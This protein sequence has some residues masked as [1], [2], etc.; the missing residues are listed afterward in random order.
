M[1]ST[2]P[3]SVQKVHIK[4]YSDTEDDKYPQSSPGLELAL[5][6]L[7]PKTS[8]FCTIAGVNGTKTNF[9][10]LRAG[11]ICIVSEGGAGVIHRNPSCDSKL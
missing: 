8:T 6:F 10:V 2:P 4:L 3:H 1:I 5:T 7:F 11:C 9:F